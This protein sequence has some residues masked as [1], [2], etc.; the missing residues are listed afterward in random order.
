MQISLGEQCQN[1]ELEHLV[2][3]VPAKREVYWSIILDL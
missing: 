2:V 1:F 3:S